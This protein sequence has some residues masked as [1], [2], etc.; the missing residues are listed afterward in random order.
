[1]HFALFLFFCYFFLYICVCW[2]LHMR[3]AVLSILYANNGINI[4][5]NSWIR[6]SNLEMRANQMDPVKRENTNPNFKHLSV[7]FLLGFILKLR[8]DENV[9][10]HYLMAGNLRR[11][12]QKK[13][14]CSNKL[15]LRKIKVCRMKSVSCVFLKSNVNSES[16]TCHFCVLTYFWE[17]PFFASTNG[18]KWN[19]LYFCTRFGIDPDCCNN[20]TM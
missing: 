8:D 17:R 11:A 4:V 3:K 15:K 14:N 7:F 5:C 20:A 1:M 9:Y 13:Y 10:V 19:S 2:P 6:S 16:G 12:A 18:H